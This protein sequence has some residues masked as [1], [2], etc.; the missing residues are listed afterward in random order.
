MFGDESIELKLEDVKMTDLGEVKEVVITKDDTLL[1]KGVSTIFHQ[2]YYLCCISRTRKRRGPPATS[3][4]A[5][6]G[7]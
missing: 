4:T 1:M 5:Q 2:Y 3:G 7:D 6:A